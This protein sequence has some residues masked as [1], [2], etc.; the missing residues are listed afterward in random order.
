MLKTIWGWLEGHF[1]ILLILAALLIAVP[2]WIGTLQNVDATL[3]TGLGQGIL[4]EG[5]AFYLV[6][7]W[8]KK[9]GNRGANWLWLFFGLDLLIAPAILTPHTVAVVNGLA[10][11]ALFAERDQGWLW[12]WSGLINLAPVLLVSGVA[13]AYAIEHN[14]RAGKA[15]KPATSQQESGQGQP[16]IRIEPVPAKA[17]P[18][19]GGFPCPVA[20][21]VM[22]FRSQ[23]GLNAHQ[24]AHKRPGE[25]LAKA[26]AQ[27][28]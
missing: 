9:Q 28:G 4:L 26:G 23:E 17:L 19:G 10:L 27:Q 16:T 21:C 11:A 6:T 13:L 8:R 15:S 7:V 25:V 14:E 18:A 5:G 22:S 2:R 1:G 3:L 20:G 24:R 12:A